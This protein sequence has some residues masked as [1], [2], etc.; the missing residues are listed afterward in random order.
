MT[1]RSD[2]A[3]GSPAISTARSDG[4]DGQALRRKKREAILRRH[5][6]TKLVSAN[7]D[8]KE[9]EEEEEDRSVQSGRSRQQQVHEEPVTQVSPRVYE[10]SERP[11]STGRI[12]PS[13]ARRRSLVLTRRL[14]SNELSLRQRPS[15]EEDEREEKSGKVLPGK[16]DQREEKSDKVVSTKHHASFN[17]SHE[18][19][20]DLASRTS[21]RREVVIQRLISKRSP[22]DDTSVVSQQREAHRKVT[23]DV[24]KKASA[25]EDLQSSL[26][27][28][29]LAS[30]S[31]TGSLNEKLAKLKGGKTLAPLKF[32][33]SPNKAA[34]KSADDASLDKKVALAA[35][36][37][38]AETAHLDPIVTVTTKRTIDLS[39]KTTKAMAKNTRDGLHRR[40]VSWS[41]SGKRSGVSTPQQSPLTVAKENP[42]LQ[43]GKASDSPS[44][45]SEGSVK[46]SLSAKKSIELGKTRHVS[47]L[48][49]ARLPSKTIAPTAA[50]IPSQ[51]LRVSKSFSSEG[52]SLKTAQSGES[53][54]SLKRSPVT[55]T[56]S[57]RK[58]K[59]TPMASSPSAKIENQHPS[60]S[61]K[62]ALPQKTSNQL[63]Y[64][65]AHKII[66]S[67]ASHDSK[68]VSK[69]PGS[70]N[71]SQ[72]DL[73]STGSFDSKFLT[74]AKNLSVAAASKSLLSAA[75]FDSNLLTTKKTNGSNASV[76]FSAESSGDVDEEVEEACN[77]SMVALSTQKNNASATSCES[78]ADAMNDAKRPTIEGTDTPSS[79]EMSN[80]LNDEF[81]GPNSISSEATLGLTKFGGGNNDKDSTEYH[82]GTDASRHARMDAKGEILLEDCALADRCMAEETNDAGAARLKA[83]DTPC[84]TM[85]FA[86]HI[87]MFSCPSNAFASENLNDPAPRDSQTSLFDSTT[88]EIKMTIDVEES[89][90]THAELG[91][92][93]EDNVSM[94]HLTA[95]NCDITLSDSSIPDQEE[96]DASQHVEAC[97]IYI[98]EN[99][100]LDKAIS[101][102]AD[103][104]SAEDKENGSGD[105]KPTGIPAAAKQIDGTPLAETIS[106]SPNSTDDTPSGSN[107]SLSS[108]H[109]NVKTRNDASKVGSEAGGEPNPFYAL[110]TGSEASSDSIAA[111]VTVVES[112]IGA[113]PHAADILPTDSLVKNIDFASEVSFSVVDQNAWG[114]HCK[115]ASDTTVVKLLNSREEKAN[116]ETIDQSEMV[117][118]RED[119]KVFSFNETGVSF[120]K[121]STFD[122]GLIKREINTNRALVDFA[123]DL[124]AFTAFDSGAKCVQVAKDELAMDGGWPEFEEGCFSPFNFRPFHEKQHFDFQNVFAE[125]GAAESWDAHTA[126]F[127]DLISG[128][129]TK[130]FETFD[131]FNLNVF[132]VEDL[133]FKPSANLSSDAAV[134]TYF[135]ELLPIEEK[136][137]REP[138]TD[139]DQLLT[140]DDSTPLSGWP[141]L[142]EVTSSVQLGM[143]R[144]ATGMTFDKV[145]DDES[146]LNNEHARS[147]GGVTDI[148]GEYRG[149]LSL[150]PIVKSIETNTE[151][152]VVESNLDNTNFNSGNDCIA[153][154]EETAQVEENPDQGDNGDVDFGTDMRK[155]TSKE[156]NSFDFVT[157]FQIPMDQLQ[158]DQDSH[159]TVA[160]ID[161]L[162]ESIGKLK[163]AGI[164]PSGGFTGT[165]P[166]PPA[167]PP[168]SKKARG[169]KAKP[170]QLQPP[171]KTPESTLPPPPP[172]PPPE[173]KKKKKRRTKKSTRSDGSSSNAS[174][175][176]GEDKSFTFHQSG[177]GREVDSN[178]ETSDQYSPSSSPEIICKAPTGLTV[179]TGRESERMVCADA[180]ERFST[181]CD[182]D[183]AVMMSAFKSEAEASAAQVP[184]Q[185]ANSVAGPSK[186]THFPLSSSQVGQDTEYT[187]RVVDNS[188]SVAVSKFEEVVPLS[189]E[190]QGNGLLL[191]KTRDTVSGGGC[192]NSL[193]ESHTVP[194][195]HE[196]VRFRNFCEDNLSCPIPPVA[197]PRDTGANI[198]VSLSLTTTTNDEARKSNS[199]WTP[200]DRKYIVHDIHPSPFEAAVK[201]DPAILSHILSCLGDPVV[202]CRLKMTNRACYKYVDKNEHSLMRD[203]VRLGG[204]SMNVRPY[205][206][207]WVTLQKSADD[208]TGDDSRDN[209]SQRLDLSTLHR[210]GEE[211]KWHSVIER[212]VSRSFGNLPPHKTGARL[213]TDS[214]VRALVTWGRSRI[215]KRGVKGSNEPPLAKTNSADSDDVSLTP[216]DTVSDWGGVTPVGSF[217]SSASGV[218]EC[219][220]SRKQSRGRVSQEELALGSNALTEEMKAS[221]QDK[222]SFIL[223]ALAACHED[224]GYC[225]GMDY[226]VAHLLR[227]LQD[228]IK[229]KAAHGTLPSCVKCGPASLYGQELDEQS[230]L[231]MFA[232]IDRS[233]VVEETCFRV[234]NSF[235]TT[236]GLR[237]FYWP[238]LRCLKTC[239][240]VFERLIKIKLPVLYDHFEHHEL[241]VGLFALGWFQTLFLYLPSMPSATVCHMW[242]IWLVE[243]SFKIFFRV[244]TAIL[245][246]SQPIL[247]NHELEGMMSYLNT[248]PDATL[249]SPDILI[250]C[251]LQIK[252]TNR[253]LMKLEREV[254]VTI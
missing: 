201:S 94:I 122:T 109:L 198:N 79:A 55:R 124:Q 120:P 50:N 29:P 108:Q 74:A 10:P 24:K 82:D 242:D 119:E 113:E 163:A 144:N 157:S 43:S 180:D 25:S 59:N 186:K 117:I 13:A 123:D 112:E 16:D 62:E 151:V 220:G 71:S 248:F 77:G 249:L 104:E 219:Q 8:E 97:M 93:L 243:R 65:S 195:L 45:G 80:I 78:S 188:I 37:K 110:K 184:E 213:R 221:L 64:R 138:S 247:L 166:P 83:A 41:P 153:M 130:S 228:T 240:L 106:V 190:Q 18:S 218:D 140:H 107:G 251:A 152:E 159:P 204:M 145:S 4:A 91:S 199:S 203:A 135:G 191:E 47:S 81:V 75:S 32:Q 165:P 11:R 88:S 19:L 147:E 89:K 30:R 31:S 241:N 127:K 42:L 111:T 250:A 2:V 212:D 129:G 54:L 208:R 234:M 61:M 222:L 161:T 114:E 239:C 244:G 182:S 235:F 146:L 85:T 72:K 136:K 224:V 22:G 167:T 132:P 194:D 15:E 69:R 35:K 103:E 183:R 209:R 223:H 26:Y 177:N 185:S 143:G 86:E 87:N 232:E 5:F 68:I 225:Q 20:T 196:V 34:S 84:D 162:H 126:V 164:L 102:T 134:G 101:E 125:P 9:K 53:G 39:V 206:W 176:S 231:E 175:V 92:V 202:V 254:T 131:A 181:R 227:I 211:G 100:S 217:T 193:K 58:P 150:L 154:E 3:R 179:E 139:D 158:E 14:R 168:P 56:H 6:P 236:Y 76:S 21:R 226:V 170:A 141:E 49:P 90:K 205:F 33:V 73:L 115:P 128:K 238:E 215:V 57:F 95:P 156:S 105:D 137:E 207:L 214:I 121:L 118:D 155:H 48:S 7:Q 23:P 149:V 233:L 172:P 216:T 169:K 99:E 133:A 51:K 142:R 67:V 229:W 210:V 148:L 174:K 38:I 17:R 27:M 98:Q 252:L 1:E 63:K 60:H 197:D 66:A 40:N 245:F 200:L 160:P 189:K 178:D 28:L 237:H 116:R 192:T 253:M 187:E 70:N 44:K 36:R 171:K 173:G 12:R 246:L 52:A 230:R 46:Q 96:V